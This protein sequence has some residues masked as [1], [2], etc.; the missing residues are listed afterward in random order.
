MSRTVL[1]ASALLAILLVSAAVYVAVIVAP[2]D[3]WESVTAIGTFGAVLLSF[4]FS[5]GALLNERERKREEARKQQTLLERGQ[6]EQV[7]WWIE[8][9]PEHTSQF[10]N[11]RWLDTEPVLDECW[12]VCIIVENR[13]EY[14]ISEVR[15][16]SADYLL[17]KLEN[18]FYKSL[19]PSSRRIYHLVSEGCSILYT[20]QHPGTRIAYRDR[21]EQM[22]MRGESGPPQ[23]RAESSY[24]IEKIAETVEREQ[25]LAINWAHEHDWVDELESE[26]RSAFKSPIPL[27]QEG[28]P[29][30]MLRDYFDT[31]TFKVLQELPPGY[32]R[33][34]TA[35]KWWKWRAGTIPH[36]ML[37]GFKHE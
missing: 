36:P 21:H 12:G 6:A 2:T 35:E 29:S 27:N 19:G 25:R 7:W 24:E 20:P 8:E 32:A 13:S 4:L 10:A 16:I 5:V 34:E 9:C 15:I 31:K 3:L 22:W 37:E 26:L 1:W 33:R 11:D 30:T 14:P 23:K 18:T 17:P 28:H